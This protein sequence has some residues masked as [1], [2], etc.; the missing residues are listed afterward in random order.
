MPK[1]TLR[2]ALPLLP[3]ALAL[4]FRLALQRVVVRGWS[5]YPN[6]APG[7][8]V[9]FH[10]LGSPRRGDVVL[11]SHPARPGLPLVKRVA[12][13]PGDTVAVD[14]SPSPRTLGPGEYL[15]LGDAPDL[16]TDSR[17]LGPV[18]REHIRARAWLI[19]WPPRRARLVR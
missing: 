16:S 14:D 10:R 18:R 2:R 7:D 17:Q 8:R 3:L 15:L 13:V 11:A 9:L 6:L 1:P 19:Y 4:A 5:M 12:A